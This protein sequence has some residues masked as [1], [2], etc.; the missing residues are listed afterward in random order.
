MLI[1]DNVAETSDNGDINNGSRT[2]NTPAD[3]SHGRHEINWQWGTVSA[4]FLNVDGRLRTA[5]RHNDGFE[6][7][8][9]DGHAKWRTRTFQNGVYTSGTQ[10]S[11]WLANQP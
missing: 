2:T 8:L 9:A 3:L 10:D 11:E 7:V 1:A 5:P 6:M 4:D